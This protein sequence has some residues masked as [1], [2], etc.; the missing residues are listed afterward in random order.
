MAFSLV[1]GLPSAT[2]AAS[3]STRFVRQL[4]QYYADVRLLAGVHARIVLLA[5]LADPAV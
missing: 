1:T 2:S 5:S 3:V 4:R